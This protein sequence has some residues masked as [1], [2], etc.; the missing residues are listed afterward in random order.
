MKVTILTLFVVSTTV[1]A[2]LATTPQ[3]RQQ[4]EEDAPCNPESRTFTTKLDIYASELGYYTF[5][6]CG[7]TIN[8][9][10]GIE[11][12]ETYTFVQ[13]DPSNY[14]HPLGFAYFPDGAHADQAEL[15]P[16]ITQTDG[17]G[18]AA[19]LTCP[20]PMYMLNGELLGTYSNDPAIAAES[21][22]E[23]NFGLDDYEPKFFL[24]IAEWV[25]LGD[26]SIKLNFNDDG[27]TKDI[28]YFCHVSCYRIHHKHTPQAAR[29][30]LCFMLL[31]LLSS[32]SLSNLGQFCM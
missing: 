25:A 18:C 4:Q 19:D 9:T 20:A 5:E 27:Y 26:F 24:P 3:Q 8:P 14:F 2:G 30:I 28:F 15:E 21:I 7:D 12:G 13:K 6:E 16:G 11:V 23:G 1:A 17:N 22:G 32:L 31:L 29:E 10:L